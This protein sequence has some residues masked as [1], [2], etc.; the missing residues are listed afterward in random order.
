MKLDPGVVIVDLRKVFFNISNFFANYF[1]H[2]KKIRLWQDAKI[3]ANYHSFCY[4]L[5][6]TQKNGRDPPKAPSILQKQMYKTSKH[7]LMILQFQV[8]SNDYKE[9]ILDNYDTFDYTCP[10][11]GARA[12]FHRH[13]IYLRWTAYL[14]A[15]GKILFEPLDI[16]RLKCQSCNSTHCILP[17]DIIPFQVYSL[18]VVLFLCE[19]ILIK[20]ESLRQ[21]QRKTG[22]TMQ[23]IYQ[24]LSLLIQSLILIEL[25][26]RQ[27]SLYTASIPVSPEKAL[28]FL[29]LP[30]TDL[31]AYFHCHGQPLFLN[32]QNTL[33]YP[34][35]FAAANA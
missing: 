20:K 7:I 24:K 35:Y 23:S 6:V 27:V 21:T 12:R 30:T 1:S 22:C 17:A 19:Q 34:L 29:L 15:Q 8:F 14:S 28:F 13:G 4:C 2:I 18:P 10:K 5:I 3:V 25:Y 33:A 31:C 9:K 11:C 32:R 16:L 26:L